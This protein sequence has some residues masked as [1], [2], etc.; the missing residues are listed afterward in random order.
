MYMRPSTKKSHASRIVGKTVR[1]DAIQALK[2]ELRNM[3]NFG[4]E[5]SK[6]D[7]EDVGE[8]DKEKG[9]KWT[10][11]AVLQTSLAPYHS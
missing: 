2:D 6:S 3:K 9:S 4:W 8:S 11:F 1:A 5:P 10:E 7:E